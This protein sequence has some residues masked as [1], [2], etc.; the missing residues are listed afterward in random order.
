[1]ARGDPNTGFGIPMQIPNGSRSTIRISTV[2]RTNEGSGLKL[3]SGQHR[4]HPQENDLI[5]RWHPDAK[6]GDN[7]SR[8]EWL[9]SGVLLGFVARVE[10]DIRTRRHS[11][12]TGGDD[13]RCHLETAWRNFFTLT[14]TWGMPNRIRCE[15]TNENG[16]AY[17]FVHKSLSTCTHVFVRRICFWLTALLNQLLNH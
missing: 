13:I 3:S 2:P 15:I 12:N 6:I 1:M 17:R 4:Y 7:V 5:E 10:I 9:R 16:N 14:K 11:G 8:F